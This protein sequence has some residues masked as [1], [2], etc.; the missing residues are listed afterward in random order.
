[1]RVH[2]CTTHGDK[3]VTVHPF[4]AGLV[5]TAPVINTVYLDAEL[6]EQ[7]RLLQLKDGVGG[8]GACYSCHQHLPRLSQTT[9][10]I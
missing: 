1:M 3:G 9:S 2:A 4:Q 7:F 8:H 10:I 6:V 5:L